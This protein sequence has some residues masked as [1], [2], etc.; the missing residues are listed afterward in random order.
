MKEEKSTP[1]RF[2]YAE[3]Q[4]VPLTPST[5]FIGVQFSP[6]VDESV[7]TSTIDKAK[8]V[9]SMAAGEF[10]EPFNVALIPTASGATEETVAEA[11]QALSSDPEVEDTIPVFQ[12]PDGAPGEV[13]ILIPRFRVQF[14]PDTSEADIDRLNKKHGVE[15]VAKEDLG[16]HSYLL[17][18]TLK[19]KQD[20]LDIA[21]RYHEDDLVTYAEPDWVYKMDKLAPLVDDPH[22]GDQ[23][24]LRKMNVPQAWG[25]NKGRSSIKIAILDEGTQTSHPDLAGKIVA[26]YDAVGNDNN[27]EPNAWDG[28]GTACAGIA[29]A[30]TDNAKGMAGVARDCAILPI[31]IAYSSSPAANWTTNATWIARGIRQAVDRGADVLSNS[32]GGGPYNTTIRNAFIY[33]KTNGRGGKGCVTIAA[34]GN[35]DRRGIGYPA[36]YPE[37]LACGASNEWDQRKSKTSLDGENWWGSNYGP[38]Q[39]FLAPG[40]HIYTTDIT[41]TG[42]YGSGDYFNRFNGTSSA[43]PNAAGVAGLILSVDPNLRQ[44]EVRDILRLTARDLGGRGWDEEHG[45]GRIDAQKALQAAARLWYQAGLRL[46]FL[47]KGQECYLRFRSFR[48]YNSGLNRIR[49]NNFNLRSYDPTGAEIDRFEY[50]ANPGGVMLPGLAVGGGSRNDLRVGG[51]LLKAHGNR[52]QWSYNWRASWGYTYWRPSSAATSPADALADARASAV[53]EEVEQSFEIA[54]ESTQEDSLAPHITMEDPLVAEPYEGEDK[55]RSI[56][57]AKEGSPVKISITVA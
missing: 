35:A 33:A 1:E 49:I 54:V 25:I 15:I 50:H 19:A 17:A 47:G 2:Y 46:E 51:V 27:Q 7:R 34:S 12:M 9:A 24:A 10:L 26:P 29:A 37:V 11:A 39:D 40:V 14:E 8:G 42:G 3:D 28:H 21:N 6:A 5:A 55:G 20:T 18:P 22:Y 44:W 57:L 53:E 16:P 36:K 4:K 56:T 23:W 30:V 52:S 31:R 45:W 43:T 41:G 48:L 38:E 13:M 32:W